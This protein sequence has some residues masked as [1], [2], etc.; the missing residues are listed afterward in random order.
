[1]VNL[2][3]N[4]GNLQGGILKNICEK[5]CNILIHFTQ[6]RHQQRNND[7]YGILCHDDALV[8]RNTITFIKSYSLY[9]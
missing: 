6:S 5:K 7:L 2:K 3:K 4:Y 1:M 8:E 9:S